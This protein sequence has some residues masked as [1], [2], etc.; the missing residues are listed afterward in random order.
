[1]ERYRQNQPRVTPI[2]HNNSSENVS[3][4]GSS[5]SSSTPPA[6]EEPKKHSGGFFPVDPSASVK[7]LIVALIIA[8]V[9]VTIALGGSLVKSLTRDDENTSY[10]KSQQYQAVFLDN[11]QVY[12]GKIVTIDEK[13]VQLSDIYYLQVEKQVQPEQKKEGEQSNSESSNT[14]QSGD[15]KISL[16]KLGKELHGPEDVMY[17]RSDKIVFWENLKDEGQVTSA[18]NEYKKSQGQ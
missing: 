9:T 7:V 6:H 12:F 11:G 14:D 2:S 17:I 15:P 13:Y 10:V 8:S 4:V 1:M 3:E 16:A 5:Q 18:I